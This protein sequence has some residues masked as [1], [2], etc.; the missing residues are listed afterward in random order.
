MNLPRLF[1]Q[2]FRRT[3]RLRLFFP[4]H[5]SVATNRTKFCE[6]FEDHRVY[7]GPQDPATYVYA[8]LPTRSTDSRRYSRRK[9]TYVRVGPDDAQCSGTRFSLDFRSQKGM[10]RRS[11]THAK[12][13]T[14]IEDGKKTRRQKLRYKLRNSLRME[15]CLCENSPCFSKSLWNVPNPCRAWKASRRLFT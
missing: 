2:Q 6:K 11:Y 5:N 1:L 8:Y 7:D 9:R 13:H 15:L 3:S 14:P 10:H 4:T 12:R